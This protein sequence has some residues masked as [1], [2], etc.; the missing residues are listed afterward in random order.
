MSSQKKQ[1]N[2]LRIAVIVVCILFF[3]CIQY[4]IFSSIMFITY[5]I[6]AASEGSCYHTH[7]LDDNYVYYRCSVTMT[8]HTRTEA[9]F[10]LYGIYLGDFAYNYISSPMVTAID[11]KGNTAIFTLGPGETM[12]F[13]V[14]FRGAREIE[15]TDGP[16]K[17]DRSLPLL[18]IRSVP[19]LAAKKQIDRP[20]NPYYKVFPEVKPYISTPS[21]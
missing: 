5:G 14:V 17:Y 19:S 9:R 12:H 15:N 1:R 7:W 6:S 21:M 10:K 4:E 2:C 16:T 11:Q 13:K 3:A 18:F 20:Q 8:N